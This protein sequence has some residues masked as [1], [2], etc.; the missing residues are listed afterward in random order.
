MHRKTWQVIGYRWLSA[1]HSDKTISV[2]GK[3]INGDEERRVDLV[4]TVDQA[5][6][7]QLALGQMIERL[8]NSKQLTGTY[9]SEDLGRA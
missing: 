6:R 7:L 5:K 9:G 1:N 3:G 2:G 8:E 4:L